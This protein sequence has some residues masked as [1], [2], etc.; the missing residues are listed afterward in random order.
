MPMLNA[1]NRPTTSL[2][3]GK[4]GVAI[5]LF[6]GGATDGL[7]R[8]SAPRNDGWIGQNRRAEKRSAFRHLWV[9]RIAGQATP[10]KPRHCEAA[11]R[12]RQSIFLAG[13]VYA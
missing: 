3:A 13:E 6:G 7:L 1:V 10:P 9:R 2:R 11:K 8:R 4:A 12:L 5:H